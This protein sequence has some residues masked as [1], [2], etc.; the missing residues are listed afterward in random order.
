M[1]G[2]IK[3][4]L[5]KGD[6]YF[7][8]NCRKRRLATQT[9]SK[10]TV[11]WLPTRYQSFKFRYQHQRRRRRRRRQRR[12]WTQSGKLRV[13]S[14]IVAPQRDIS[15]RQQIW[16]WPFNIFFKTLTWG[17]TTSSYRTHSL[18]PSLSL[19]RNRTR[20]HSFSLPHLSLSLSL[21]LS[22]YSLSL[23]LF[24]LNLN[25]VLPDAKAEDKSDPTL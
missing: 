2:R 9:L 12:G 3:R 19:E 7:Q 24:L 6:K 25:G 15:R 8:E 20:A 16:P 21:S 18:S 17:F 13:L 4:Q 23:S 10:W 22:S 1:F 5:T 11:L 14:E